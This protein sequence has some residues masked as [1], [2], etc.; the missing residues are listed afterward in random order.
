MDTGLFALSTVK[1]HSGM[2]AL[3]SGC[4]NSVERT[5]WKYRGELSVLTGFE[6]AARGLRSARFLQTGVH[7][8]ITREADFR[9]KRS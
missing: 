9:S 5:H 1:L 3:R 8:R 7:P 6:P 2:A 4:G